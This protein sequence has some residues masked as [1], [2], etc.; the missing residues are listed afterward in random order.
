MKSAVLLRGK[1]KG[2]P[3]RER[4]WIHFNADSAAAPNAVAAAVEAAL[5]GGAI[6]DVAEDP[7]PDCV[8]VEFG[9]S[10]SRYAVR[11]HATDFFRTYAADSAV[12]TRIWFALRRDGI[13]MTIPS[14]R[15][16][17]TPEDGEHLERTRSEDTA[18]KMELLS[19]VSIFA[20]LHDDERRDLAAHLVHSP[21]APGESIVRQGTVGHDLYILTKGE[22]EVIVSVDGGPSRTVA[23]L[24]A[25]EFFGE[26]GLLTGE[27]RKAGVVAVGTVEAWRVDKEPIH[28]ILEKRPAV[29]E[30]IAA[31]VSER[32]VE[33]AAVREG[34]SEEAKRSRMEKSQPLT[35]ARIREFFG[36]G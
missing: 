30:A 8:L 33:L 26:M 4:R 10:W 29:A 31:L 17:L 25:P 11:Y 1:R 5:R 18:R 27:P 15:V 35:L 14:H 9:D 6:P 24:R 19:R 2:S 13:A 34:L 16:L 36:I 28:A 23:T 32:E 12:R 20:P 7:A 22:A 3:P 21:F